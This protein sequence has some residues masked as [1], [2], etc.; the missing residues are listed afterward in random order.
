M[1]FEGSPPWYVPDSPLP[2][3]RRVAVI[4]PHPDDFDVIGITLRLF[5]QASAR[6]DVAVLTSGS[7]GV[8]DDFAGAAAPDAKRLVRE[9]EQETSCAFFGL[10]S[11]RL[12][13][14]RLDEDQLGGIAESAA[15][16]ERVSQF[17]SRSQPELIFLP[18][19]NDPNLAHKRTFAIV[20]E[21]LSRQRSAATL[22]LNRDPKT[23]A[24]REDV[25]VV[26]DD[27]A[28]EWKRA[29]LRHHASR[30]R[31]RVRRTHPAVECHDR[32]LGG[33]PGCVRRDVR[34]AQGIA[35]TGARVHAPEREPA[36]TY[37]P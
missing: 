27:Q 36:P 9:R 17:L 19:G 13:F 29:L 12:N 22:W 33:T 5:H 8:E 14:L 11:E 2:P 15:S 23:I 25:Y 34:I 28:A 18:H 7:S 3:A 35:V 32:P 20:T 10:P 30:A 31:P 16:S 37:G 26:F 21:S 24:M 1:L 4:A 6:I